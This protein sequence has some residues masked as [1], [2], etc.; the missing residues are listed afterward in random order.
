MAAAALRGKGVEFALGGADEGRLR[1][2]AVEELHAGAVVPQLPA[3][4]G[5]V[6]GRVA[7]FAD[8]GELVGGE[9]HER[10]LPGVF[11]LLA[12]R[13]LAFR[14]G[15]DPLVL[16]DRAYDR[17]D[18]GSEP[19]GEVVLG[20]VGLLERVVQDAGGDH[21]VRGSGA[22]EQG[23][24]LERMQ[25]ERSAVRAALAVVHPLGVLDRRLCLGKANER[26]IPAPDRHAHKSTVIPQTAR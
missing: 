20:R 10:V 26:W 6:S 5:L 1:E 23:S 2:P 7:K 18:L 17:R 4:F 14:V 3:D 12:Q 15:G 19:S 25:D 21:V 22:V 24:D 16:T 11:D 9:H 13:F 8:L